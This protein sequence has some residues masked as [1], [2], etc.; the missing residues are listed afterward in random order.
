MTVSQN[1]FFEIPTTEMGYMLPPFESGGGEGCWD[2]SGSD[3][4]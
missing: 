3:V 2:F 1:L 4:M